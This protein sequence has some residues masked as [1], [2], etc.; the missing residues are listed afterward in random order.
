MC[1]AHVAKIYH[2]TY[3]NLAKALSGTFK[4]LSG[5]YLSFLRGYM[6][7]NDERKQS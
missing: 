6:Y 3:T 1:Y 2:K 4:T 7:G 5:T